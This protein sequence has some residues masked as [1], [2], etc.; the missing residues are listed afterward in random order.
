MIE[1][2]F[3]N[4][5]NSTKVYLR[6]MWLESPHQWLHRHC[7]LDMTNKSRLRY[8]AGSCWLYTACMMA[9]KTR[10]KSCQENKARAPGDRPDRMNRLDKECR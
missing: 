5:E 1:F 10:R 6:R 4:V 2:S 3:N 7:Q 9:V 8:W